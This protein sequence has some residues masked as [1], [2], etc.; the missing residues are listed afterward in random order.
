M[1]YMSVVNFVLLASI[2]LS[3]A[4]PLLPPTTP[5]WCDT[6]VGNVLV[7]SKD[8]TH[9]FVPATVFTHL[10]LTPRNNPSLLV[11]W[12]KFSLNPAVQCAL[13]ITLFPNANGLPV[14]DVVF[15]TPTAS[16]PNA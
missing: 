2:E 11:D 14:T 15:M 10:I 9:P 1:K 5:N 16:K 8:N 13:A 3:T 7:M 6:A 12:L 4:M